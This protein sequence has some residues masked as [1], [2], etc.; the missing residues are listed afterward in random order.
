MVIILMIKDTNSSGFFL[1]RESRL[2]VGIFAYWLLEQWYC[3][4]FID[5]ARLSVYNREDDSLKLIDIAVH[6]ALARFIGV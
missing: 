2:F 1:R 3:Y 4:I 5:L 6:L